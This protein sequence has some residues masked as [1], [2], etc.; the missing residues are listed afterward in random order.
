MKKVYGGIMAILVIVALLI[1]AY[2]TYYIDDRWS[3]HILTVEGLYENGTIMATYEPV[4]DDQLGRMWTGEEWTTPHDDDNDSYYMMNEKFPTGNNNRLTL[5]NFVAYVGNGNY[6]C[7]P[8]YTYHPADYDWRGIGVPYNITTHELAQYDFLRL[9]SN[10]EHTARYLQY[11]K[12]FGKHEVA[13]QEVRNNTYILVVTLGLKTNLENAPDQPV[14]IFWDGQTTTAL[15]DND[16]S[17]TFRFSAFNLDTE[18]QFVWSNTHLYALSLIFTGVILTIGLAF[19]TQIL[20]IKID[21]KRG[22]K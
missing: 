17:W 5:T 8:N 1:P 9:Y 15:D 20:D 11:E 4:D 2:A 6:T 10:D 22:R 14:Y 13:F 7:T 12:S 19:S 3:S 21:K 18:H 16:A